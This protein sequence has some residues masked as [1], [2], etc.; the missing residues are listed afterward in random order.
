MT[1]LVE[2]M[3]VCVLGAGALGSTIAATL[4]HGGCDVT[5]IGRSPAHLDA[6]N[7]HGLR[8][9]HGEADAATEH[10]ERVRATSTWA[11]AGAVDVVV[12][13]VKA[14]ASRSAVRSAVA[15][16]PDGAVFLTLQNGLGNEEV[17][18][19]VVGR[20]RVL[21]GTTSVAG[22]LISPGYVSSAVLGKQTVVGELDG[23]ITPR[24]RD[25]AEAFSRAGLETSVT[26]DISSLKWDKLLTNVA[27]GALS[28]ITRLPYGELYAVPQVEACARQAVREA[29]AVARAAGATLTVDDPAAV[30]R[31]AAEGL[32]ADF[33][34]SMLQSV[35]AGATTEIDCINGAVVR[36]G[37]R[38]GIPTPV[39]DTLVAAVKGIERAVAHHTRSHRAR[40]EQHP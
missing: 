30:W 16:V 29:M 24:V 32:P 34:T 19:S 20:R 2:T 7:T 12:V 22:R 37:Q 39:N 31:R 28:A 36:W 11:D 18:A 6:I 10:V 17:I 26:D 33:R 5:L 14:P 15:A 25:L 23:T 21:N 9:R 13:L 8:V 40:E 3:R 38:A 35:E 27:T 1:A 4:S